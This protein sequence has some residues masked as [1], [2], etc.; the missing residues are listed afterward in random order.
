MTNQVIKTYTHLTV[1]KH[2]VHKLLF[3]CVIVLFIKINTFKLNSLYRLSYRDSKTIVLSSSNRY[4]LINSINLFSY[5]RDLKHE[6]VAVVG[7]EEIDYPL[8]L[9]APSIP[10]LCE[11]SS[12]DGTVWMKILN[13]IQLAQ[14]I[15]KYSSQ[16]EKIRLVVGNTASGIQIFQDEIK[17][18]NIYLY[19]ADIP[20]LLGIQESESSLIIGATERLQSLYEYI[21]NMCSCS[22]VHENS[23]TT[24]YLPSVMRTHM[25]RL[26]TTEIRNAGCVSGNLYLAKKWGFPSDLICLLMTMNG[27]VMIS[28]AGTSPINYNVVDFMDDNQIQ[29]D[30]TNVIQ[31]ITMPIV[32]Q[33]NTFVRSYK[34]S[35]RPQNSHPIVNAGF[36]ANVDYD[37]NCF[38]N[39]RIVIGNIASKTQRMPKTE[40]FM[41]INCSPSDLSTQAKE[42]L[43]TLYSEMSAII[44]PS[45]GFENLPPKKSQ[46]E[47][48]YRLA[49]ARNLF[50]KYVVDLVLTFKLPCW[51][52][53]NEV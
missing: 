40:E 36:A 51:K 31:S 15:Q 43:S 23:H 22:S 38:S 29:L 49:T 7:S 44:V 19:I 6:N 2:N 34:V 4:S 48:S 33:T 12:S 35:R 3:N 1:L 16:R 53:I 50:L 13:M 26:A 27:S 52:Q 32:A 47:K 18:Q 37:A 42:L 8:A 10:A 17:K 14:A 25:M 21:N 39:V 41:M 28:V 46:L 24:T 30:G 5:S 45:N 20:E 9:S 11:F